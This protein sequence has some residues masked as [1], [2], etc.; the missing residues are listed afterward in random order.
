MYSE[1]PK[2]AR[3]P[4]IRMVT[5]SVAIDELG[6]GV[7]VF[8]PALFYSGERFVESVD[9]IEGPVLFLHS[10]WTFLLF[11]FSIADCPGP[12]GNGG[13]GSH[14]ELRPLCILRN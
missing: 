11:S 6:V 14:R 1:K 10:R 4:S 2:D 8:S 5:S 7:L 9:P 13:P 12:L 3:L